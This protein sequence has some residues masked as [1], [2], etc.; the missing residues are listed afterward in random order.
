MKDTAWEILVGIFMVT[1][2]YML[3]RPGSPAGQAVGDVSGAL[4]AMIGA[5]TEYKAGSTTS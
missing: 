2:V 5:A 3:V 1:I 4:A